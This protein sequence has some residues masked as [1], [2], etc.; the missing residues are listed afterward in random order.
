MLPSVLQMPTAVCFYFFEFLQKI[1]HLIFYTP[2]IFANNASF[3]VFSGQIHLK[4]N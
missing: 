4:V 2:P 1:Y 3:G